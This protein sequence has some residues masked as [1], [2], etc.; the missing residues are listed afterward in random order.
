MRNPALQ[1]APYATPASL[2]A[3]IRA[4]LP[5]D[6]QWLYLDA[7]TRAWERHAD[8]ADREAFCHRLARSAVR[9]HRR[10]LAAP[11]SD[12]AGPE[13]KTIPEEYAA[14]AAFRLDR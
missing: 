9:R 10:A 2:P 1:A 14:K 13:L 8:F 6:D 11:R 7:F 3:A 5:S 12:R 4:D